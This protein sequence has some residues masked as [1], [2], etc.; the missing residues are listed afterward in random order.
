MKSFIPPCVKCSWMQGTRNNA[1]SWAVTYRGVFCRYRPWSMLLHHTHAACLLHHSH[2]ML[3]GSRKTLH[4]LH[5]TILAQFS[6]ETV[7][8]VWNTLNSF[9]SFYTTVQYIVDPMWYDDILLSPYLSILNWLFIH[10]LLIMHVCLRILLKQ[11][12]LSIYQSSDQPMWSLA[13]V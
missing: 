12:Y 7:Y 9:H 13:R 10:K 4:F 11:M 3:H 8:M 6:Y 5:E 2:E 1:C